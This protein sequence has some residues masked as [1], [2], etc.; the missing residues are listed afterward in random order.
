MPIN[1]SARLNAQYS[2][3]CCQKQKMDGV[4]N[5]TGSGDEGGVWPSGTGPA[6]ISVSSLIPSLHTPAGLNK[7]NPFTST[8]CKQE[9]LSNFHSFASCR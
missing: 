5:E 8:Q 1:I 3:K 2:F 7:F 9:T 4:E 6:L